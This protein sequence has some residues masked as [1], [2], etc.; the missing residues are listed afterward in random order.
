VIEAT[1]YAKDD[2]IRR[3]KTFSI[4]LM[5]LTPLPLLVD[6]IL[7]AQEGAETV[8]WI[9]LAAAG[10]L[11]F[12]LALDR[13]FV[14]RGLEQLALS[15]HAEGFSIRRSRDERTFFPEEIR[16]LRIRKAFFTGRPL[17]VT[18]DTAEG[19]TAVA[20]CSAT[21]AWVEACKAR[22]VETREKRPFPVLPAAG[23]LL[24]GAPAA[25]LVALDMPSS[26]L[27]PP[28]VLGMGLVMAA[29]PLGPV[30]G[31]PFRRVDRLLVACLI[32]AALGLGVFAQHRSPLKDLRLT[33]RLPRR[34]GRERSLAIL[35]L[36]RKGGPETLDVLVELA[37]SPKRSDR[38]DGVL[39][40]G[41]RRS[42]GAWSALRK[43]ARDEDP[44]V[45]RAAANSIGGFRGVGAEKILLDILKKDED[46]SV[47]REA[48]R[49]MERITGH[50][51]LTGHVW[52]ILRAEDREL[53]VSFWRAILS[54]DLREAS[55][56][57]R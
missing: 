13:G 27:G 30:L 2:E 10:A 20:W 37:E 31:A 24:L 57:G 55:R 12:L 11:A 22:G 15:S 9:F 46:L 40:L 51:F 34:P 7:L 29:Y 17:Q 8:S 18:L 26:W 1:Y 56:G 43:A 19:G 41:Y 6:S 44:A 38:I 16:G 50:A 45:R 47:A 5:V 36:G 28:A 25:A 3:E 42:S 53:A 35:E 21:K 52:G 33:V 32:V 14:I 39:A 23:A 48:N 4:G 54:G 49:S